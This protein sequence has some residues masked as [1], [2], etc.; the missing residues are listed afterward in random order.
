MVVIVYI[1]VKCVYDGDGGDGFEEDGEGYGEVG[2]VYYYRFWFK[3][4]WVVVFFF[5]DF[6][7]V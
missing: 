7:L 1:V 5:V 3:V 6:V 4:F 2:D